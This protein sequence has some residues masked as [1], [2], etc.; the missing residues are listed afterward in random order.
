MFSDT[1]HKLSFFIPHLEIVVH[2]PITS[3]C[4]CPQWQ[5]SQLNVTLLPHTGLQIHLYIAAFHSCLS[6]NCLCDPSFLSPLNRLRPI[7]ASMLLQFYV[8]YSSLPRNKAGQ[9]LMESL[10]PLLY[11][12]NNQV[13]PEPKF[14]MLAHKKTTSMTSLFLLLPSKA[15]PLSFPLPLF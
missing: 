6:G 2:R 12:K 11:R 10:L 7:S 13:A 1:S 3:R 15:D 8:Q 4:L 9:F 5:M 14:P